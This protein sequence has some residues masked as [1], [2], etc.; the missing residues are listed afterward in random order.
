MFHTMIFVILSILSLLSPLVSSSLLVSSH[1]SLSC[2][3]VS[4]TSNF[5][6][7]HA[8]CDRT[9]QS[10]QFDQ[11]DAPTLIASFDISGGLMR[12]STGGIFMIDRLRSHLFVSSHFR[13]AEAATA[14]FGKISFSPEPNPELSLDRQE[15]PPIIIDESNIFNPNISTRHSLA[16]LYSGTGDGFY[17]SKCQITHINLRFWK[18]EG[19]YNLTCQDTGNIFASASF[20]LLG[21]GGFGFIWTIF[22]N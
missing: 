5:S 7:A 12:G 3:V 1:S 11:S 21:L 2:S 6:T 22:E 20:E 17:L 8:L 4:L 16:A 19:S 18:Y 15:L 10:I 14:A 9:L 13:S